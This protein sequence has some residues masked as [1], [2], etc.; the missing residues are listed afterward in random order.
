MQKTSEAVRLASPV[1]EKPRRYD[2]RRLSYSGTFTT[3]AKV[4]TIRAIEWT[5]AKV[6]LL[7]LIR[8]F[9][10]DGAPVGDRKSVV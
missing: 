4:L 10:R 7:S 6:K 9:E 3:P 5:T 2:M 1:T 8:S